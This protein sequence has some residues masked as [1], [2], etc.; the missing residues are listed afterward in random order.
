MR[1]LFIAFTLFVHLFGYDTFEIKSSL[2]N[3][4]SAPFTFYIQDANNSFTS[5]DILTLHNLTQLQKNGQLPNLLGPFWSRFEIKN[6]TDKTKHLILNNILPGTNYIDVYIYKNNILEKKYL[7]GDMRAQ[8][9]KE[10]LGRYSM[11]ELNLAKD[12]TFT[13]ISKVD[14]FN[15]TNLSW[16]I[17]QNNFFI[18]D[19][20]KDFII[21]GLV[22]GF[23]LLFSILNFILYVIY[24]VSAYLT[25]ALHTLGL[26]FYI[27]ALQGILYTLN[28]G[29]NLTLL[30][31]TAW[32]GPS[33]TTI[34]FLIFT[35]QFFSMRERYK[36]F[37]YVMI[38]LIGLHTFVILIMSYAVLVDPAYSK[39]STL[40]GISIIINSIYLL[41]A[42]IYMKEIG[43]KFYLFGQ[44][45][46]ILA[47]LLSTL[48]IFGV[49][50]YYDIYRHLVS[51]ALFVDIILLLVAQSLK[52]QHN[53]SLLN[54][55]KIALIENSR[56]SSIGL[57]INNITHQWKHPLS[58][59]GLSMLMIESLLKNKKEDLI[60]TLEAEI[61]KI[62]Y[63][64]NLMKKTIDE[65]SNYYS[66]DIKKM[67]FPLKTQSNM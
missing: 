12:E 54:N 62:S 37:Y 11:F 20:S 33:I 29:I 23:F 16:I 13:I 6:T 44:V 9:T 41:V 42:G 58:H 38:G 25:I 7:L 52:T 24:R 63:S 27:L 35:N 30:T 48:S 57:A 5:E 34:L 15:V 4:N 1:I 19:E 55:S 17:N 21:F 3:F 47:V 39:Y 49:I 64:L 22:G 14:N 32:V 56:Y 46:L 36:K 51:I 53:I 59:I 8:S 26:L 28:I 31:Y 40:T 10:L 50:T 45:L 18:I 2:K 60:P 43:S 65:F 66:Q 67:T 61:P